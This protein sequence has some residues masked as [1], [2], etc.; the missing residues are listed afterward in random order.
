MIVSTEVDGNEVFTAIGQ[1]NNITPD[2]TYVGEGYREAHIQ[3]DMV[4]TH[5]DLTGKTIRVKLSNGDI[6]DINADTGA[7]TAVQKTT[8]Q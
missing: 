6:Y 8:M 7:V 2:N 1:H 3:E 5:G 4:K